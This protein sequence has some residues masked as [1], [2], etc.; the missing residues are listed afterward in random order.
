MITNILLIILLILLNAFFAMSEIAFVS[1]NDAKIN[2]MSENGDKKAKKIVNMLK[3]PS[4]F[5][6]TIQIGITLA[7]FLASAYASESFANELV[8][9]LLFIPLS[10]TTI[11][12]I[13]IFII[14]MILS[15]FTLVFGELVPKKIAMKYY[16]KISFAVVGFLTF[17]Y[18]ATKPFVWILSSST[19][20]FA[21]L[22]GVDVNDEE[23][24]TEE[25]IKMMVD[26]GNEK[27]TIEEEERKMIKNV[28][29]FNDK[30]A[31]EV[32]IPRIDMVA[33]DIKTTT[34]ELLESIGENKFSRIPIYRD[35]IDNIIGILN[36][37][38]LIL[39]MDKIDKVNIFDLL[40]DPIFVPEKKKIQMI[41]TQMKSS[42]QNMAIVVD[43]YGGTAGL[44]TMEDIVEEIV[45]DITDEY[46]EEED[47]TNYKQIDSN[48]YIISGS[49]KIHELE[50]LFETEIDDNDNETINGL[51]LTKI[52]KFPKEK[53][54]LLVESGDFTFNILEYD[55]KKIT[56]IKVCKNNQVDEEEEE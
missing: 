33:L 49:M 7:G 36:M 21:K 26:I 55:D 46:D 5:L 54:D 8:P 14:T 29:D 34:K 10:E 47:E 20:A 18:R 24:V 37:K 30:V 3:D 48:T 12:K 23:I 4:K 28:F 1:L 15:Y 43:E 52:G 41:F 44:I 32:M 40:R 42:K 39:C 19:N 45:G 51:L 25:E 38:D 6:A 11:R 9:F 13:A 17:L 56:K 31:E 22:F 27:G 2:K 16:E 35:S 53:E 50:E